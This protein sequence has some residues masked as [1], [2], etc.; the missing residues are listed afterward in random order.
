MEADGVSQENHLL[1]E[2]LA[3]PGRA[4]EDRER[5]AERWRGSMLL[6]YIWPIG[7]E[8]CGAAEGASMAA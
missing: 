4:D 7:W 5:V 1:A 6:S 8:G 2:A 3:A